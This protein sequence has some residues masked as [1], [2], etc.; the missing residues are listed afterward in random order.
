[1]SDDLDRLAEEPLDAHDASILAAVKD[2][3][4]AADPPPT[5]MS[6]RIRFAMTVASLEADLA[7]IVADEPIGAGVRTAYERTTSVTFESGS[8]SAMLDIDEVAPGR[9]DITGWLS[10]FP[11]EVVLHERRQTRTT[12]TDSTGRFVF[13]DVEPGLVHLVLHLIDRPG[14]RP[15]ITPVIEL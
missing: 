9:V 6:D 13:S 3:W 14:S 4:S 1:M 7:R 5:G 10:V 11:A 2:L 15:I 8:V 12:R